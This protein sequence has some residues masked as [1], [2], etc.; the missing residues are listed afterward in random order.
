MRSRSVPLM[1]ILLTLCVVALV[2]KENGLEGRPIVVRAETIY[3]ITNGV[4]ENG[5]I[6][7]EQGRIKSVAK[8]IE[9][10]PKAVVYT[11]EVVM[12]GMIDAHVH[13]A[14]DRSSRPAGPVTAEWKGVEHLDLEDGSIKE[15]LAGGVTSVITRPGS[16][17]ISSGAK[18]PSVSR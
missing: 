9:I 6:L 11:A 4:V 7:I 8:K 12:P 16:G 15:A 1:A 5:M 17:V 14:L 18:T 10:P 13:F 2:S 3:T